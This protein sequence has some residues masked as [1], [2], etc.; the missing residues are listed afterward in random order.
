MKK[1]LL[2]LMMLV[3]LDRTLVFAQSDLQSY[4][5]MYDDFMSYSEQ[6]DASDINDS[7]S[8]SDSHTNIQKIFKKIYDLF[9]SELKSSM[10]MFF[11]IFFVCVLS[12]VLKSFGGKT[13]L[14]DIGC[15]G[16]YCVCSSAIITNFSTINNVCV[17]SIADLSDFMDLAVPTYAA[18]LT[19]CGYGASAASLQG[20]FVIIS[21]V[22]THLI[23]NLICPLLFCCALLAVISGISTTIELSR[24]IKLISKTIKYIIGIIMTVFAG[25]LTFT[26]FAAT[27]GDNVAVKTA[28]YAISNFVPVVGGCLSEALNGIVQSSLHMKNSVG[29]LGFITLLSICMLPVIKVFVTVFCFRLSASAAELLAESKLGT[30][31]DCI[32]DVLETMLGMLIL[33]TVIFMLLIGIISSV[34]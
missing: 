3:V 18:L 6:Y 10:T 2:V 26:G 25:I 33:V 17:S 14:A 12:S 1:F 23:K 31:L 5:S 21:I 29:Y 22:I 16:C 7:A 30:V 8:S 28:K 13:S 27:A 9:F 32:C 4:E 24:F 19:G 15:Y 11:S 20:V 34:G